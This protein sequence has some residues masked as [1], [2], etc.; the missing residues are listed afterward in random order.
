MRKSEETIGGGGG[1]M[2]RLMNVREF[3][4]H[5]QLS[6]I[7]DSHVT[8]SLFFFIGGLEGEGGYLVMGG[9]LGV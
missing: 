9:G 7:P 4:T 1:T 6:I 5:T 8:S 2:G 3:K